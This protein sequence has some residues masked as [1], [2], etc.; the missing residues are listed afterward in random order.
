MKIFRSGLV[1]LLALS[2]LS[3]L[4][5]APLDEAIKNIEASGILRYRY[6][7]SRGD[8]T[9]PQYQH[10]GGSS[11]PDGANQIATYRMDMGLSGDV[12]D[13]FN[14][15]T[16]LGYASG[17]YSY[18]SKAKADT[19]KTFNLKQYFL[20]YSLSDYNTKIIAGRQA[21]DSIWAGPNIFTEGAGKN[22]YTGIVGMGTR[23]VTEI[24]DAVSINVFGFDSWDWERAGLKR[25]ENG[26]FSDNGSDIQADVAPLV[27]KNFYGASLQ[28]KFALGDD[29]INPN[30]HIGY[31]P[32]KALLYAG[33]LSYETTFSELKYTGSLVYLGN[34]VGD[35]LKNSNFTN[36]NY[37][38]LDGQFKYD[39][40]DFRL[41]ALHYGDTNKKSFAVIED[42][43]SLDTGPGLD[44]LYTNGSR[45]NG[46]LGRNTFTYFDIG[47]TFIKKLR[48]GFSTVYGGTKISDNV[49]FKSYDGKGNEVTLVGQ[50][51]KKYELIGRISYAH[52]PKLS[53]SA[54]YAHT[55]IDRKGYDGSK[56]IARTQIFYRF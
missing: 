28:N 31:V 9:E 17:D 14:I 37:V 39:V 32:S 43:G 10:W 5:A 21:I 8:T 52:T 47:Y 45:L 44:I 27:F 33:S 42:Q 1:S 6:Y 55:A 19:N 24:N 34:S 38:Q 11:N 25:L 50:G 23:F 20:T 36:G 51:G 16:H 41:G 2:H 18:G 53:L 13:N 7:W 30:L 54:F 15:F 3:I 46:D 12:A 22:V 35:L 48:L 26:K 49:S 4:N 40:W 56:H 29:S